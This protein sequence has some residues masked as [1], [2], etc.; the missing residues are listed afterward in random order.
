M[1]KFF[2][3]FSF[4]IFG[5]LLFAQDF[6]TRKTTTPKAL[7]FYNSGRQAAT[8]EDTNRAIKFF[9]K[10]LKEDPNFIDARIQIAH[11]KHD[12]KDYE[13]SKKIYKEVLETA[14]EYSATLYYNFG[15]TTWELGGYEEAIDL[16]EEF[17]KR[18]KRNE[19]RI[20]SAKNYIRNAVFI[21]KALKQPV[22]YNPQRLTDSINTTDWEYLPVISADDETF[23]FTRR[24]KYGEDFYYA[25]KTDSGWTKA[26]PLVAMNTPT[27]EGA[28]TISAD[29]KWFI[30]AV[31]NRKDVIGK[32]DLFYTRQVSGNKWTKPRNIGRPINSRE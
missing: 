23:I 18:E 10:A 2:L 21:A 20:A 16:F 14:P 1:P 7:K 22:P 11:L 27:D 29:G 13:G 25:K 3:I 31:C 4:L 26:K 19:R 6:T 15:L 12:S 8:V 30:Y 5:Q 32:C 9:K 28:Q 17:L 24:G